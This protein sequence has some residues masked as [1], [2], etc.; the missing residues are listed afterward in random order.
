MRAT[1]A[2]PVRGATRLYAMPAPADKRRGRA[3]SVKSRLKLRPAEPLIIAGEDLD[4]SWYEWQIEALKEDYAAGLPV[5]DIAYRLG[6]DYRE[7]LYM[8]IDQAHFGK[9]EPR[10][11][12]VF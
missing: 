9:L 4:F 5:M 3:E 8:I 6:K 1:K 12:G 2:T 11:G 10:E 7:V